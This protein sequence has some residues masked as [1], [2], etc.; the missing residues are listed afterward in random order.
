MTR[1]SSSTSR[2]PTYDSLIRISK[3][4][5]RKR[6]GS[7]MSDTQQ[8][9][10]NKRAI[11]QHGGRL[12]RTFSALNVS[13]GDVFDSAQWREALERVRAGKSQGVAIAYLDRY[14]RDTQGG[15][16]F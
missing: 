11:R 14:G 13:G 9:D 6:D 4:G 8:E 5:D 15:L 10:A 7:L 16:A 1:K 2:T 3:V 12:G